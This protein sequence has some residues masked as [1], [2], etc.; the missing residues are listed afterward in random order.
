MPNVDSQSL[1]TLA[2]DRSVAGR[3]ALTTTVTDLFF[4]RGNALTERER[5]LMTDILRQLVDNVESSVRRGLAE[6]LAH[7]PDAPRH[8][9]LALA[10]DEIGVAHA[11]L[12]HSP[13]LQDSELVEI[14]HHRTLEHQLAIAMRGSLSEAVSAAL[15]ETADED[16]IKSLLENHGARISAATM[17]YL[18]DQS[19]R[20]DTY[21]NPLIARPDLSPD[22]ARRMYWWVSAAL[23]KHLLAKFSIDPTE[24]DDALEGAV[25]AIV[26]KDEA[27]PDTEKSLNLAERISSE[28]AITP[29]LLIQSL[30]Q[31]QIALFEAMFARL[32]DIRVAQVRRVLFERGGSGLAVAC[33]AAGIAPSVFSS[34]FILSRRARPNERPPTPTEIQEM[35]EFYRHV[36]MPAALKVVKTWQR[37]AGYLEAIWNIDQPGLSHAAS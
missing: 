31:G 15:V 9:V 33:R 34:I 4:G 29:A 16:V 17:D 37:D 21:Q 23:R 1:F 22:L 36:A 13:V 12:Q 8:L 10:N 11:V 25:H 7:E 18:V 35:M 32:L 30:R 20:V 26:A 14:I 2:H 27:E 6:R 24:L 3:Q 5:A 28:A 19:R